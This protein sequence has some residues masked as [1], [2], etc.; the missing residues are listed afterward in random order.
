[1]NFIKKLT[2]NAYSFSV[3]TKIISVA[4]GLIYT[5]LYS[6]YL[7]AE[8]RG[9]ASVINNFSEIIMMVMCLGIYQAYPFFKKTLKGNRYNEF[10]NNVS[11]LFLIYSLIAAAFIIIAKPTA[12][13]CVVTVCVPLMVGT[14]QFNY[15][16][17]IEN[18]KVMN[19]TQVIVELFDI[20]FLSVLMIFTEANYFF[21]IL[22]LIT[23]T[24]F[25]FLLAL[26]NIRVP[27]HRIR[28]TFK[29]IWKYIKY[30]FV[31]M[32]TLILM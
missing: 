23:R 32:L 8:L 22:F 17:M 5:V 16:V 15:L 2:G 4:T 6:R 26:R 28:P 24:A 9:V 14:R 19:I 31:P 13:I 21:C 25:S 12:N 3:I 20:A 27:L 10:I 30:G 11:G 7:G 1:M 18:P 29:G